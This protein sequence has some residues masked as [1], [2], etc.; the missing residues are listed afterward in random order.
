MKSIVFISDTHCGSV[1]GLT[2]PEFQREHKSKMQ[3]EAW[4]A[5]KKIVDK[6]KY[7][8]LLVCNGDMIDGNQQKAGGAELFTT[9][10]NVQSECAIQCIA[11]WHA[12]KI[13]MTYGTPYH[14]GSHEDF[15]YNIASCLDAEIEGRLYFKCE[16]LTFDVRHKVGL[17]S[18]YHGRGTALLKEMGWDLMKEAEGM[19][20]KVDVVVRSH[21]HYHVWIET[22]NKIMFTTPAL[23]LSRGRFGS[24]ECSGI[25]NWGVIHLILDN[26]QIAGKDVILWNLTENKPKVMKIK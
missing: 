21:V 19:S 2:P 11:P 17:S 9:D 18:I 8:D 25:T 26:G 13:L 5:Y 23:Q 7:P 24:R 20:P 16:G 4:N 14:T 10:R 6:Y 1:Y 15:E 3:S 22:G 12:K